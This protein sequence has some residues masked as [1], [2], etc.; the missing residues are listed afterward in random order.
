MQPQEKFG[1]HEPR[2][3]IFVVD[4]NQDAVDTLGDLLDLIGYHIHRFYDPME[5]LHAARRAMPCV[6]ISDIGMPYMNG[7]EL[8][9]HL[10]ECT[11]STL[12]IACS[13]WGTASDKLAA[14]A[15]GFAHHLTKPASIDDLE[16]ILLA[17]PRR[18]SDA[19]PC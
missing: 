5:A 1:P 16:P 2:L 10:R 15:A 17:C 11:P 14:I 4:D 9:R 8:A 18:A 13:G 6:V 12:L 7:Y 19:A 3:C